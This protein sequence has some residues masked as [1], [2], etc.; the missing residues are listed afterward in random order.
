MDG[1]RR[2]KKRKRKK[3]ARR[4]P[5]RRNSRQSADEDDS[6]MTECALEYVEGSPHRGR[7]IE[8]ASPP[9]T[10]AEIT[11]LSALPWNDFLHGLKAGD[12][13]QVCI[14]SA[15]EAASEEVQEAR[16]KSAEPKS[17]REERFVS[18]S[19]ESLHASGNPVYDIAREYANIFPE[20]IPAELPADRGVRHQID[21]VPGSKYCVT[22]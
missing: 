14:I 16:P 4:S 7:Y 8:V 12:I 9:C 18:Q 21:L 13:E 1:S 19:W 22:R 10:A 15:A 6:V 17:A 20:K 11:S 5:R 2:K 3:G